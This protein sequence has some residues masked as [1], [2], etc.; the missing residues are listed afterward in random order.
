MVVA[1]DRLDPRVKW[2]VLIAVGFIGTW[3]A[4]S[5]LFAL[6]GCVLWM[7]RP[8]P[9]RSFRFSFKTLLPFCLVLGGIFLVRSIDLHIGWQG[10]HVNVPPE[11]L[12]DGLRACLRLAAVGL[13]GAWIALSTPMNQLKAAVE[14]ALRP[15]PRVDERT[16][17]TLL[18]LMVRFIPEIWVLANDT[19][20]AQAA[21]FMG[22][23]PSLFSRI[24]SFVVILIRKTILTA[25][26]LSDAMAARCFSEMRTGIELRLKRL[27][28]AILFLALATLP[29]TFVLG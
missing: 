29:L 22:H 4:L 13:T 26:K 19:L 1:L 18:G 28:Y 10:V 27:D 24:R 8:H 7:L 17:S 16:V 25:D 6:V 20:Q 14:W 21:R 5:G 9:A 3:A 2:L 15:I 11:Q 12:E 23:P